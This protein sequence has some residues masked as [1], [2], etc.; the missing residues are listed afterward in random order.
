MAG[1]IML[2][3]IYKWIKCF[4]FQIEI[5]T[6]S[7]RFDPGTEQKQHSTNSWTTKLSPDEVFMHKIQLDSKNVVLDLI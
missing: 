6:V 4:L 3:S 1:C 2:K 5:N 7:L